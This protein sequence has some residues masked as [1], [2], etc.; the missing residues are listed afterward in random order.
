MNASF[1]Q[2]F[3]TIASGIAAT[4]LNALWEDVL[5]VAAVWCLL[6]V[7]PS[8]NAATRYAVWS[9]TLIAAVAVPILTTVPFLTAPGSAPAAASLPAVAGP[10]APLAHAGVPVPSHH[11]EPKTVR[12]TSG[13]VDGTIPSAPVRF[14]E[15]FRL[16]LP[17]PLALGVFGLWALLVL[18]SL[19]RLA[20]GLVRL[21]QL[22][23]DAL[24]LPVEYRD[25]MARWSDA[26][27]GSRAVRLCVSD[28]VDV[29][30]AIGLFDAMILIP[31]V[32]LDQLT[33]TEVDQIS[34]HE[35]A[36]LRRA[37]D[38]SN[39]LQRVLA[40]LLVWNPA[41]MFVVSQLELEREVACDDWVL[42]LTGSVRPY[43]LCLTKMAETSSWPR[44]P[45]AA[46]AVFATRKQ[47][48]LRIERLLGASRNI[49]TNL[50]IAPAAAAIVIVGALAGAIALVA[51]SIAAPIATTAHEV[52]AQ[53]WPAPSPS[54][55]PRPATP[56]IST[57]KNPAPA[58][59]AA[60]KP[61]PAQPAVEKPAS[62]RPAVATTGTMPMPH[63]IAAFNVAFNKDARVDITGSTNAMIASAVKVG[64]DAAA[65][66]LA[67]STRVAAGGNSRTDDDCIGCNYRGVDW[68][69]RS[70]RGVSYTGADLSDAN[71]NRTDFTGANF[72]G[73]DFKH[74][75]LVGTI[76]RNAHLTG[77]DFTGADLSHADFSG[78]NVTGCD[79]TGAQMDA[80]QVRQIL[81]TCSGC[82]FTGANLAGA[83]LSNIHVS[84]NDFTKANLSNANLSGSTFSGVD[85]SHARLDGAN[86]NGTTLTGCD[87]SDVDLT[88]VD[89][90]NA[91]LS[92]IDFSGKRHAK[93]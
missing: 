47:I 2:E 48:S 33:E 65:Q 54:V 73:V 55:A 20:I 42:S 14:P 23:R 18:A 52:V 30:V 80:V 37:D 25:L 41:V 10:A 61:A 89:L 11:A 17:L 9:A 36:H 93:P 39:G 67:A 68:S 32:L 86:L 8:L 70:M 87:L 57:A 74:A 59:A 71:L 15:R 13:V 51:P 16:S 92:G 63:P 50:A 7:W 56:A 4:A 69:G 76:F 53:A 77:C 84:G 49:A 3:V 40:A 26:N 21:E 60:P 85:F 6:R 12:G 19:A 28:D 83:D 1:S 34:L 35:L 38:W 29:P 58:S 45:I 5:L 44:A 72:S 78:A 46:P 91:R 64:T 81:N 31:R 66:A 79:F 27:K 22:K 90:A 62:S 88:H 82:D 24:P 75:N 43:A